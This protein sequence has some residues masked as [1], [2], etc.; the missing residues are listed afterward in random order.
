M[1]AVANGNVR[2]EYLN[3]VSLSDFEVTT[4]RDDHNRA[5]IS[6][7]LL[8]GQPVLPTQ[9]FLTSF[10]ARIGQ[11]KSIFN[12][13]THAE[14][15]QT[16]TE[17]LTDD[18]EFTSRVTLAYPEDQETPEL[19]SAVSPG[20]AILKYDDLIDVLDRWGGEKLSYEDGEVISEHTPRSGEH[21]FSI[22]PDQFCNRFVI[23][24]PI[25]GYGRPKTY[26]A[27][28]RLVCVNGMVAMSKL[29]RSDVGKGSEDTLGCLLRVLESYDSDEG[30]S[31]LRQRMA[32]SQNSWASISEASDLFKLLFRLS[33]QGCFRDDDVL[34]EFHELI[35]DIREDYGIVQEDAISKKRQKALP[36]RCTVAHLL[37]FASEVSSHRMVDKANRVQSWMGQTFAE[38]YDL[39]GSLE[40]CPEF[41]DFFKKKD[42]PTVAL[43]A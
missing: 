13:Y 31:A 1:V 2:F 33:D 10:L 16:A 29:F 32:S 4:E 30:F 3:G 37:Q 12:L 14:V 24:T 20:K 15:F 21:N 6:Q 38:E 28:L 40:K 43:S 35:G 11:G 8:R 5:Y 41:K 18:G 34:P 7:C 36:V 25:D 42:R 22:G 27:L 23:N 9:R 26:L 17:R 39:E 19:L